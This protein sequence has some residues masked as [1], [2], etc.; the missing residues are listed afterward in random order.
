MFISTSIVSVGLLLALVPAGQAAISSDGALPTD[1]SP[2]P[3]RL[4]FAQGQPIALDQPT[5]RSP[6]YRGSGR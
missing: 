6:L 3:I 5:D 4:A 1:R 2:S